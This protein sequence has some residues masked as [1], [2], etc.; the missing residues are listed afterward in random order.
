MD[1]RLICSSPSKGSSGRRYLWAVATLRPD[2]DV[3]EVPGAE[4]R[5]TAADYFR[6]VLIRSHASRTSGLK[7]EEDQC[8]R[9]SHPASQCRILPRSGERQRGRMASPDDHVM[10]DRRRPDHGADER[11]VPT[12]RRMVT[13]APA[14][15]ASERTR[16]SSVSRS[17]SAVALT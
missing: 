3:F 6:I 17:M 7:L 15:K 8:Q 2:D 5:D 14:Q 13:R 1:S 10:L 9:L 11:V 4:S 12:S 16:S